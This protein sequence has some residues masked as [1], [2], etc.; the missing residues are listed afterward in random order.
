METMAEP[1]A[2]YCEFSTYPTEPVEYVNRVTEFIGDKLSHCTR[3]FLL[4]PSEEGGSLM[5]MVGGY[6]DT[7]TEF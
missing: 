4:L 1:V 6:N 3:Y 5:L 2:D 7:T